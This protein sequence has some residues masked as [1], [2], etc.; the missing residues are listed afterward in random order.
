[1]PNPSFSSIGGPSFSSRPENQKPRRPPWPP[2]ARE[3]EKHFGQSIPPAWELRRPR[4]APQPRR[5]GYVPSEVHHVR[6]TDFRCN[7]PLLAPSRPG[8]FLP[9]VHSPLAQPPGGRPFVGE[10]GKGI[11]S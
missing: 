11:V 3:D 5:I 2:E 7:G 10:S 4:R 1:I 6:Q 9:A 8:V